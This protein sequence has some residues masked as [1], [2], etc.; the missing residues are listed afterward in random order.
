MHLLKQI[1]TNEIQD[2]SKIRFRR[3]VRII[4]IDENNLIPLLFVSNHN[5]HKLPGG[6]IEDGEDQGT[7]L[8]RECMEELGSE[9]EVLGE[10][11]EIHEYREQS[12]LHQISYCYFGKITPKSS[13]NFTEDELAWGFQIIWM[14]LDDAI[15]QVKKDAPINYQGTSIQERDLCFLEAY[16]KIIHS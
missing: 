16:K 9:I 2:E 15:Q 1:K 7:A 12:H 3:A 8:E 13:P 5:Y 10:V 4:W 14:T 6:W 11:W